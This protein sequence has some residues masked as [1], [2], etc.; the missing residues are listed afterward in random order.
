MWFKYPYTNYSELNLDWFL[1]QFKE[2]TEAWDAQKVD[3]E[4]FKLD[5]TTEFNTLSGKFDNLKD[6]FDDLYDYVHD[7]FDNL[8]VQTEINNKLDQM[9]QDG[10][11]QALLQP[12]FNEFVSTTN[13]R[14]DTLEGRMDAF[15][16]LAEG[17][18][19]GDAELM[20]IRVAADGTIYPTAGDAVRGQVDDL[21]DEIDLINAD[22]NN[23]NIFDKY[24]YKKNMYINSTGVETTI[25]GY[26]TYKIPVSGRHVILF[27]WPDVSQKPWY[28][29]GDQ[30]GIRS[31]NSDTTYTSV[32]TTAS[33]YGMAYVGGRCAIFITPDNCEYVIFSLNATYTGDINVFIDTMVGITVKDDNVS[34][35]NIASTISE[36]I[37]IKAPFSYGASKFSVLSGSY[38]SITIPVNAGDQVLFFEKPTGLT[39]K[40]TY[41]DTSGVETQIG[42]DSSTMTMFTAPGAGSVLAYFNPADSYEHPIYIPK[43]QVKISAKNIIGTVVGTDYNGLSGVAFGTSLTQRAAGAGTYGYLTTLSAHS[44]ITFD[45]QGIGSSTILGDGGSLDMLAAI[46]AYTDYSGKKVCILE[47]FVNDWYQGNILGTYLDTTETTVCG[48][49]RSA[50]NYMLTQNAD[51]TVFLILDH[52]GRSYSSLDCS[53]TSLRNGKRQFEYYEEIAKV[54]ESLGVPV[55]KEYTCSGMSELMPQYFVD[56]IHPNALGAEQSGNIIWNK[57]SVH[58]V[59]AD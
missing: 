55:I 44:G 12:M 56:N 29:L 33:A 1:Q 4:Q 17:S 22:F 41:R 40:G 6:A 32:L 31:Y 11:L 58:S 13:S 47:G 43:D 24:L 16:S 2:L 18:T 45:N 39:Q 52:Y 46:K 8:D 5:V 53:S 3:Y 59:N 9:V 57:M 25:S 23:R 54:A 48:C 28:A 15:S 50:L 51:M 7:Y 35:F 38:Y 10:T 36:K 37:G 27:T 14:M 19:T 30:Y 49:V 26:D 34:M 21:Q 20:D 42:M